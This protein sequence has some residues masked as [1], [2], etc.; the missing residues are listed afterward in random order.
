MQHPAAATG[1]IRGAC[2]CQR[3]RGRHREGREGRGREG[4]RWKIIREQETT[5]G[6]ARQTIPSSFCTFSPLSSPPPLDSPWRSISAVQELRESK[7]AGNCRLAAT[8]TAAAAVLVVDQLSLSL[9]SILFSSRKS[10][11][12]TPA[13]ATAAAVTPCIGKREREGERERGRERVMQ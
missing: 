5:A 12:T 6:S 4:E 1:M 10:S 13:A 3:I 9:A 2:K 8:A 7:S 11:C